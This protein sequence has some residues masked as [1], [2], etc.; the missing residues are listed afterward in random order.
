MQEEIRTDGSVKGLSGVKTGTVNKKINPKDVFSRIKISTCIDTMPI[1][2]IL[3]TT[4]YIQDLC[5]A[6]RKEIKILI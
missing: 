3:G 2:E 1:S 6:H 5:K 4:N